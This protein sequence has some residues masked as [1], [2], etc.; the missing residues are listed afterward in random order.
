MKNLT[1]A[2][3]SLQRMLLELQRYDVMIKYRPGAEMQLTDALSHC[4]ARASLE[5]KLD[6]RVD[7]ITFMKPWIE[8]LEDSTQKDPIIGAVYQ[9]T[10]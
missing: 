5:I 3:L 1:N 9:L 6:V 4:P 10:H 8:K 2:P 7:Y